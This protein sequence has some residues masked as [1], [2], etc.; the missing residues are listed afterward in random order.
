MNLL[1]SIIPLFDYLFLVVFSPHPV[2]KS[3]VNVQIVSGLPLP[4]FYFHPL[5]P[6]QLP[7][8][9]KTCFYLVST[10][11]M[12]RKH[13]VIRTLRSN[14]ATSL[15]NYSIELDHLFLI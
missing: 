15:E 9:V 2:K 5:I 14:G 4:L 8:L 11:S 12:F 7:I 1:K 6:C 3:V 10:A 13:K